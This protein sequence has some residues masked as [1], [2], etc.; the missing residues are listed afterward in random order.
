MKHEA[1]I[2]ALDGGVFLVDALKD[3]EARL[4]Q[5]PVRIGGVYV[6]TG[7]GSPNG[8]V[9]GSVGDLFLRTDG[10]TSTTL[11]VKQSGANTLT[12]WVAK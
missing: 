8:S 12:G 9:I 7:T 2:R 10:G 5:Q 3:I 6:R 4:S 11:Y 1:V